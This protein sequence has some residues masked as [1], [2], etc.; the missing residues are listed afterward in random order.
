MNYTKYNRFFVM[1]ED[2]KSKFFCKP[3]D[4][5]GYLK[6]ETGN[7]AGILKCNIQNLRYYPDEEYSYKLIFFGKKNSRT[8]YASMGTLQADKQGNCDF[9]SRFD[10]LDVDGE[11]TPLHDFSAATVVA[12]SSKEENEALQLVLKGNL[13]YEFSEK[14]NQK[15]LDLNASNK[16]QSIKI[17]SEKEETEGI[18]PQKKKENKTLSYKK[19]ND[20]F[21]DYLKSCI[22]NSCKYM[23]KQIHLCREEKPFSEDKIQGTWWKILNIMNLPFI[24]PGF[25]T[26]AGDFLEAY[27]MN[28][29]GGQTSPSC[30]DLAYKYRH[31]LFG[32]KKDDASGK[33]QKYYYA[34]PGKY[35]NEHPDEG[36]SGFNYWQPL[37][38]TE[39]RPG[40]YGYWIVSVD[41][42]TGE[43]E[44]IIEEDDAVR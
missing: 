33:I 36:K 4:I 27:Q 28:C 9:Y 31:F 22:K 2:Q 38:G 23:E 21:S 16:A 19:I 44:Q 12:V 39:K 35:A 40:D 10:P 26:C 17:K 25:N 34:I 42:Y 43:L 14:E 20:V 37:S 18:Q 11:G 6:I 5:K 24:N 8:I 29:P 1:L 13:P 30:F 32:L 3:G 15:Q 41:P 7:E